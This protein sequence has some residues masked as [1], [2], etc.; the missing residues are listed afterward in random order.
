MTEAE[1]LKCDDPTVMLE[2]LRGKVSDRKLRLF[3]VACCR[4]ISFLLPDETCRQGVEVAERCADGHVSEEE[5]ASVWSAVFASWENVGD[6]YA[7]LIYGST[8]VLA[9]VAPHPWAWLIG[10]RADSSASL[11]DQEHE[12]KEAEA[13]RALFVEQPRLFRDLVGNPFRAV[14][15]D[16]AWRTATVISLAITIYDERAFDRLPILADALE[17][18]GCDNADILNHCR[19]PGEHVRG[20]WVVDKI[21]AR[22]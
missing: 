16:S 4:R 8:M 15:V 5:Q 19:Q 7:S 22:E 14:T 13:L 6:G 12:P 9:A 3:A 17:D 10:E 1:W 21:L 11:S 2:F 18:A 20:C